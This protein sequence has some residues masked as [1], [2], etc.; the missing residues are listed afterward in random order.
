MDTYNFIFM[1]ILRTIGSKMS[2]EKNQCPGLE[3]KM[4]E[5]QKTKT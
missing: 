4:T 2:M 5:Q 3:L 1:Q